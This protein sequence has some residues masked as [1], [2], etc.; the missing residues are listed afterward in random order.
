MIGSLVFLI[1][2]LLAGCNATVFESPPA[3]TTVNCDSRLVGTWRSEGLLSSGAEKRVSDDDAD[4]ILMTRECRLLDWYT[5]RPFSEV[6]EQPSLE[7]LKFLPGKDGGVA[8]A[9]TEISSPDDSPEPWA[10]GNVIFRYVV[11]QE[12]ITVYTVDNE[13]VARLIESKR[14]AS[15]RSMIT[16]GEYRDEKGFEPEYNNF[17][18]GTKEQIA[19]LLKSYPDIF[20]A[21]PAEILHRYRGVPPP[22]SNKVDDDRAGAKAGSGDEGG[23]K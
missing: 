13:R 8:Y 6:R 10:T 11:S 12:R 5:R 18:P 1:A 17:V 3:G 4:Y 23:K 19:V 22:R 20:D 15:G 2:F 7:A 9:R 21:R 14:I 16:N